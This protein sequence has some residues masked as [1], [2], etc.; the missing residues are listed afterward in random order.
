MF[1]SPRTRSPGVNETNLYGP[2]P[3]GL[4]LAGASRDFAPMY[5]ENTCLGI[6]QM[7][8]ERSQIG[9]G[10]DEV[11]AHRGGIDL[12]DAL[13]VRVEAGAER[14]G[15]RVG[16]VLPVEDDV[17]GGERLAVVPLDVLLELPGGGQPVGRDAA[18]GAAG[19]LRGQHRHQ[20]AVGVVARQR[21]VERTAAFLVL[22]AGG[23]VRVQQRRALPQQ[24]AQRAAAAALRRLVRRLGRLCL[25]D[26]G[27]HRRCKRHT[28]AERDHA[29]HEIA[30]GQPAF[31]DLVHEVAQHFFV[32]RSLRT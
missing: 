26:V 9:V 6:I 31:G 14:A 3:T 23:E 16:G 21:F 2:V 15:G 29:G 12:L 20:H 13:H 32:H 28:H 4:R 24:Q 30:S 25:R 7:L 10:L 5:A 22:G 19:D 27:Q 8:Q 17:V 1:A 11:D 18:V